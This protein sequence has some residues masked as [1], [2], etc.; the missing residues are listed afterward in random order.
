MSVLMWD[1]PKKVRTPKENEENYGFEDGPAGG[2]QPNMNKADI[3]RWKAKLVGH[4][5]GVP[6]VEIRRQCGPGLMLI[7][8]NLGSG[9]NY[10]QYEIEPDQWGRTTCGINVHIS[11]N[12]PVQMTFADMADMQ[13]AIEEAKAF[14]EEK[15]PVNILTAARGELGPDHS[16]DI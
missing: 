5:K 11:M 9:Y 12:G 4:T 7:I 8:I 13:T 16:L 1:K 14:L 15:Y 3:L 10:K 6:Q 2:Y